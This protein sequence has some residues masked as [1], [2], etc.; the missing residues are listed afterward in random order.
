MNQFFKI[1][2]ILGIGSVFLL[3]DSSQGNSKNLNELADFYYKEGYQNGYKNGY[4]KGYAKALNYA[5]EK[6]KEY[7][8]K[9]KA[10]EA[11]KY[12]IKEKKITYP[13]IFYL[14]NPDN[15]IKIIIKNSEI[16]KEIGADDI[17]YIPQLNKKNLENINDTVNH[18]STTVVS[19]AVSLQDIQSNPEVPKL[20]SKTLNTYYIYMPNTQSYKALL[21]K[22]GLVYTE[23][24]D[25]LKIIFKNKNNAQSFI[26]DF[27][28]IKN[29]DY[30][31]NERE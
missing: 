24:G 31:I 11:G 22:A 19:N 20:S 3:A 28:L 12:L 15:S 30:F 8:L 1:G 17:L 7:A 14:K 10:Y 25:K 2:I 16:E 5:K 26:N 18:P 21:N 23:D 6:L 13:E 9:I 29:V 4:E 27:H